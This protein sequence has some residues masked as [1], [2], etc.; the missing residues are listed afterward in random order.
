MIRFLAYVFFV[1]LG[2]AAGAM[3]CSAIWIVGGNLS[4]A[5]QFAILLFGGMV[6]MI[7]VG[8]REYKLSYGDEI[9]PA[10]WVIVLGIALAILTAISQ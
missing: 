7:L 4:I 8:I 2:M 5:K 6:A 3:L 1:L 10:I 9:I